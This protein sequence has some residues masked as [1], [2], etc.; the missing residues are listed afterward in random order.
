MTLEYPKPTL[1][2]YLIQAVNDASATMKEA[3]NIF[4]ARSGVT[5]SLEEIAQTIATAETELGDLEAESRL[6]RKPDPAQTTKL[7]DKL[8]KLRAERSK[9]IATDKS[10]D[11]RA[12]QQD[13]AVVNA[14]GSLNSAR[15]KLGLAMLIPLNDALE[16][17]V[18]PLQDV[19][20]IVGFINDFVD[21]GEYSYPLAE[22]V[23]RGFG[24]DRRFISHGVNYT[25]EGLPRQPC[26]AAVQWKKA[27]ADA[28]QTLSDLLPV[29]EHC[30]RAIE[31]RKEKAAEERMREERLKPRYV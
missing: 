17:A 24:G 8:E 5:T 21:F 23:V 2:D 22:A 18:R 28:D 31:N 15:R 13:E 16:E 19:L 20:E 3:N 14:Y 10:L 1:P 9:L 25:L 26:A 12:Q 6:R 29:S 4:V 27:L 30:R 7:Q 11:Q